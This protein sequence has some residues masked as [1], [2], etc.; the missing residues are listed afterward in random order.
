MKTKNEKR[1]EALNRFTIR[2]RSEFHDDESYEK[3]VARK[4]V[5]KTSLMASTQ[6]IKLKAGLPSR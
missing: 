3:Y 6:N 1:V 5:E 4:K 2:P